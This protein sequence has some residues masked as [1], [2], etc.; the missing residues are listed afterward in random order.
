MQSTFIWLRVLTKGCGARLHFKIHIVMLS[1]CAAPHG[2]PPGS[3][4]GES[5]TRVGQCPRS[6]PDDVPCVSS[7]FS[8]RPHLSGRLPHRHN[9]HSLLR[10][11][12][13]KSRLCRSWSLGLPSLG[14]RYPQLSHLLVSH[15][16]CCFF[17]QNV[18]GTH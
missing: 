11:H 4:R 6:V 5:A 10:L 13:S 16:A 14:Q 1:V 12:T 9:S 3:V 7:W 17:L 2:W 18:P 15:E 8:A